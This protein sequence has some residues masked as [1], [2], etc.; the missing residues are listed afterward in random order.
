MQDFSSDDFH[1]AC[2]PSPSQP[3]L[4]YFPPA[5]WLSRLIKALL[6]VLPNAIFYSRFLW[7]TPSSKQNQASAGFPCLTQYSQY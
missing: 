4:F 3:Q 2:Q 1:I 5:L 7:D 6:E